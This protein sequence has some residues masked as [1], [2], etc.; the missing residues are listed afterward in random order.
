MLNVHTSFS[1]ALGLAVNSPLGLQ[2]QQL[3]P[4]LL[5]LCLVCD[6]LPLQATPSLLLQTLCFMSDRRKMSVN[7]HDR[8]IGKAGRITEARVFKAKHWKHYVNW[9]KR[10]DW[11]LDE[12]KPIKLKLPFHYHRH[13]APPVTMTERDEVFG[14]YR[15]VASCEL[16]VISMASCT[17]FCKAS[18]VRWSTGSTD[19]MSTLLI[20]KPFWL[21]RRLDRTASFSSKPKTD[22]QM[23]LMEFWKRNRFLWS[24]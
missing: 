15:A 17:L 9:N 2:L 23:I 4:R 7:G 24:K 6:L 14:L 22:E 10:R 21:K 20:T 16:V 18:R 19:W 5:C 8:Q 13:I 11:E 1:I 3:L 12:K